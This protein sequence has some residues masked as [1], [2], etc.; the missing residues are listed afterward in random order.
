MIHDR[1]RLLLAV[2]GVTAV[3]AAGCTGRHE[4]NDPPAPSSSPDA[5]LLI[6]GW[7]VDRAHWIDIESALPKG[8][9]D[10]YPQGPSRHTLPTW[11]PADVKPQNVTMYVWR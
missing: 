11:L 8:E 1:R 6:G 5:S 9:T 7:F 2:L 4:D 3:V 10:T